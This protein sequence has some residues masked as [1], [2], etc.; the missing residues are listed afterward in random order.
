MIAPGASVLEPAGPQADRIG[1]LWNLFFAVCVVVTVLIL[2]SPRSRRS[3]R[4]HGG[5]A[6]ATATRSPEIAPRSGGCTAQ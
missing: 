2:G 5:A 6:R 3:A 1:D 4:P